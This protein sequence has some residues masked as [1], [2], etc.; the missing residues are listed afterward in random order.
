MVIMMLGL[1]ATRGFKT[2]FSRVFVML[3]L[4][5]VVVFFESTTAAES[6]SK[7]KRVGQSNQTKLQL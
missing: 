3:F 7:V 4:A 6:V 5:I 2:A 1:E